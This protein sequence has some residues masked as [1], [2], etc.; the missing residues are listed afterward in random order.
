VSETCPGAQKSCVN[1]TDKSRMQKIVA[2]NRANDRV[3]NTRK[4]MGLASGANPAK[5]VVPPPFGQAVAQRELRNISR[6]G[7]HQREALERCSAVHNLAVHED[8][9]RYHDPFN[10]TVTELN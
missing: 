6:R 2:Q 10:S 8:P 1:F 3:P 7:D 4:S 5:R 9:P